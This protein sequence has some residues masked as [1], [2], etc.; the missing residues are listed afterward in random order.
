ME[1]HYVRPESAVP[2][3]WPVGD[4][5]LSQSEAA[6]PAVTYKD[7]FRDVR[8]QALIG[9]ALANTRDLMVAAANIAA[10]REQ[11]RIQRAQ[12]LP[13]IDATAGTHL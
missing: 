2:P 7:I 5:Y 12:R 4:P 10:A 6:L 11:Y 13:E 8:L 1:P 9:Q 3:S